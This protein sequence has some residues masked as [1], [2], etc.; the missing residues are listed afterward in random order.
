[1]RKCAQ[2]MYNIQNYKARSVY[3]QKQHYL[4][5]AIIPSMNI[6]G[7]QK[8]IPHNGHKHIHEEREVGGLAFVSGIAKPYHMHNQQ[9][10][11]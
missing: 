6:L 8:L 11:N 9:P 7:N 1:M 4:T 5:M 2:D 10:H 3:Q